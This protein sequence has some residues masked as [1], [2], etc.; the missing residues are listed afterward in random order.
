ME[1]SGGS[2]NKVVPTKWVIPN[3]TGSHDETPFEVTI[4]SDYVCA[5]C[6]IGKKSL[7]IASQT[8]GI[9]LRCVWE[10]YTINPNTPVEGEDI[11]DHLIKK[12][13]AEGAE[14]F[15]REVRLG[16]HLHPY[17][18]RLNILLQFYITNFK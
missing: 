16:T 12:Y 11:K 3:K 15:L 10:P 1:F 18:D 14:R 2:S 13:G 9:P 8:L 6:V 5:W 17:P 7:E 4:I